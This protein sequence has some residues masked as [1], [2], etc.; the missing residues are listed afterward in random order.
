MLQGR[1]PGCRADRRCAGRRSPLRTTV[2]SNRL[3]AVLSLSV[4]VASQSSPT[5]SP[6]QMVLG[7]GHQII[8]RKGHATADLPA[9]H[10]RTAPHRRD[11][12]V[13]DIGNRSSARME[14]SQS[15]EVSRSTTPM[16]A[17]RRFSQVVTV[18]CRSCAHRG[19]TVP[20]IKAVLRT[21]RIK[22]FIGLPFFFLED[23]KSCP[24]RHAEKVNLEG[25]C[26]DTSFENH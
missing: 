10:A 12:N 23:A 14:I 15:E 22:A 18:C 13:L 3:P 20:A 8:F 5:V 21:A 1:F 11:L 9:R 16:R 17:S 24:L 6:L 2:S 7:T 4:T 25:F 19:A 26:D